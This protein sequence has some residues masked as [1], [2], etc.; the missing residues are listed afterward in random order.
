VT[1]KK[2]ERIDEFISRLRNFIGDEI[3]FFIPSQNKGTDDQLQEWYDHRQPGTYCI[4][5]AFHEGV[6]LGGDDIGI[7]AKA[8]YPSIGSNYEKARLEFDRSWYLEKTA[9]RIEQI[10]GRLRRGRK[11]HYLPGAKQVY[12]ADSAWQSRRLK[13]LLS[14]DFR[15]S[16]KPIRR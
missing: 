4:A 2:Q 13:S 7:M 15:R 16:I 6:D 8:P 5:W 3:N 12:I 10:C 14:D 9:Y 11:D 1:S